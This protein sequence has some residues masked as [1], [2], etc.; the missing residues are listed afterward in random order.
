[1]LIKENKLHSQNGEDGVI[2]S[3]F[4]A[5]GLTDR[6]FVEISCDDG[7]ESNTRKLL[8]IDGWSGVR[9]SNTHSDPSRQVYKHAVTPDNVADVLS[10]HGVQKEFDLLSIDVDFLDFH[11]L[12]SVLEKYKPRVV[13]SEYNASLGP[14][15]DWVVPYVR[16][17][18][19]DG[20]NFFGASYIAFKRLAEFYG[21][22]AVYCDANGVNIFLV[23][24]G[25][26][27]TVEV[28]EEAFRSPAYNG[29]QGHPSDPKRRKYLK[30]EHYLLTGTATAET[31]FGVISYFKND[32]YIG[33]VFSRGDYWELSIVTEIGKRLAGLYG[34]VLDIGAHIGS[35]SIAQSWINK[36]LKFVCFEPQRS[37]FLLLQRNVF[38][39]ELSN[40]F[41]LVN[42]AASNVAGCL[43]LGAT[44]Q[45]EGAS[46]TRLI[47][48]GGTQAVNLGGVQLGTDGE[49]CQTVCIDDRIWPHVVYIKVDVEGAEPLVF[50]GMQ[51]LLRR[52]LP[53]IL[54]EDRDDRRLDSAT[55][56]SIGVAPDVRNFS[57][58]CCLKS[59]GYD[60]ERR[61][62]D[63]LGRPRTKA[64]NG[65]SADNEELIPARIFQTWKSKLD[66][67]ENYTIWSRTFSF[68]NPHF[69]RVLWD[70]DD[71]HKFISETFPWFLNTYRG[72]PLEIYRAD[73]IR[74]FFLYAVGGI[75]ADMDVECLRPLEYLLD[76]GDVLLG[77]MGND[78][79]YP[80]SIPNAIMASKPRQEFWLL[81]IW[82]LMDFAKRAGHPE[83]LTG[84][85]L[86]KT[87][88][89]L[90]LASDPQWVKSA[91][92]TIAEY[93]PTE[94]K[95][96]ATRSRVAL[97]ASREWFAVDWTDPIHQ[98][99][100]R[101]VIGGK[102]LSDA[103][104]RELFPEAWMVTYWTH[105]W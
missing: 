44:V 16:G 4:E 31:Q 32:M 61:G 5:I 8:E 35:H 82:L 24:S 68:H 27:S 59:L 76:R 99:L 80:H 37:L 75:Y 58:R 72:Y 3:I 33:N 97:L 54:F 88:V 39:N 49:R 102:Q 28:P 66:F 21:Y 10:Q 13:V 98:I 15:A 18:T 50:Y 26:L 71:N 104:K 20:T 79:D 52:D 100:R 43:T 17:R 6:F 85:V 73:A 81:V 46:E 64:P 41:E 56:D 84:P 87:A 29:G 105:N 70:D 51:E 48:Y 89:D 19:W 93:L 45:V 23:Q 38:E 103:S 11:I 94:L 92:H 60:L 2:A 47:E 62:H 57:P 14:N 55:L 86:L 25:L 83:N 1:L 67:P 91:I 74:Y 96:A 34:L 30:S 69:E 9:I 65:S 42:A 36:N 40:R 77:R 7:S 12:R 78:P 101:Q 53:Q 63:V 90:Y 22:K 95:P